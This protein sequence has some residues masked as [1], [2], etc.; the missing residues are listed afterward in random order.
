[1]F[2]ACN[3][4][5]N[6]NGKFAD[7]LK[8]DGSNFDAAMRKLDGVGEIRYFEVINTAIVD[9]S[10]LEPVREIGALV[11]QLLKNNIT[12][13]EFRR[14]TKLFFQKKV[15]CSDLQCLIFIIVQQD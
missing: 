3:R 9:L 7:Y 8:F 13:K 14:K 1:M 4:S 15:T 11:I 5:G 12:L 2:R 6:L 10:F